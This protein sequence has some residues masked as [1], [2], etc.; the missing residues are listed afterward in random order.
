MRGRRSRVTRREA[1]T[2]SV[3]RSGGRGALELQVCARDRMLE[4]EHRRM[5]GLAA[6]VVQSRARV[7]GKRLALLRKPRA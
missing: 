6:K 2:S 3:A 4:P 7:R 5:Q 1:Q